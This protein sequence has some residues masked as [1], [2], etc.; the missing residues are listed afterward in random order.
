MGRTIHVSVEKGDKVVIEDERP[1]YKDDP[2]YP[3]VEA[4]DKFNEKFEEW[5]RGSKD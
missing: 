3:I 5:I 2:L 1:S 4:V